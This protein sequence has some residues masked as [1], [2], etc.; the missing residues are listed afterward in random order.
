VLQDSQ[1]VKR[2]VEVGLQN[3]DFVEIVSG[4]EEGEEIIISDMA[5]YQHLAQVAVD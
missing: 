3:S 1:A 4:L 5:D 2:K